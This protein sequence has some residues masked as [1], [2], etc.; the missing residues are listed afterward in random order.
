VDIII[1][2]LLDQESRITPEDTTAAAAITIAATARQNRND[3]T[4]Y[5]CGKPGHFADRCNSNKPASL[6][7]VME[8]L[9]KLSQ[10]VAD[11]RNRRGEEAQ[12][13]ANSASQDRGE[14][15]AYPGPSLI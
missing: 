13:A 5:S 11:I 2:H 14:S 15:S 10:E 3:V 9:N 8:K 4:C 12:F 1:Q 6:E 7:V